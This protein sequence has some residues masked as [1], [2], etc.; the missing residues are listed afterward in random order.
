MKQHRWTMLSLTAAEGRERIFPEFLKRILADY[1]IQD[2]KFHIAGPSN[3]GIAAFYVA[4]L[5]PEYFLSITAFP[6]VPVGGD[7]SA[8][9]GDLQNVRQH[10]RWGAR[11]NGVAG[12]DEEAGVEVSHQRHDCAIHPRK[13][14]APPFGYPRGPGRRAVVRSPLFPSGGRYDGS[15]RTGACHCIDAS[16]A[17]LGNRAL[18]EA[19]Q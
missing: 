6:G 14:A 5:N 2:N 4:S 1:K 19:M 11:P 16:E 3:G 13:G 7:S 8:Y 15:G 9:P 17:G 10:V 18:V 12:R